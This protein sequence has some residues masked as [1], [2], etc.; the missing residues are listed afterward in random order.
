MTYYALEGPS[1]QFAIR[2]HDEGEE[3]GHERRRRGHLRRVAILAV[4]TED[5]RELTPT[6]IQAE[7]PDAP[8]LGNVNYHLRVLE[9]ARLV[10]ENGGS[11]SASQ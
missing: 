7:L 8:P 4:L 10:S 6:Q 1:T 5:G 11:Y 2:M 9:K 3:A